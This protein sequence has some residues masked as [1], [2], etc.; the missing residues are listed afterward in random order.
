MVK[1]PEPFKTIIALLKFNDIPAIPAIGYGATAID[2]PDCFYFA[3]PIEKKG[4]AWD[5]VVKWDYLIDVAPNYHVPHW[6]KK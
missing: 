3:C 2:D 4:Y 1:K 6:E 5:L